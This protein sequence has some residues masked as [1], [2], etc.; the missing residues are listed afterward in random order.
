MPLKF[1]GVFK[2]ERKEPRMI[3]KFFRT[4]G[5][6]ENFCRCDTLEEYC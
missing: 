1:I 6:E 4:A 2:R 3:L 5:V